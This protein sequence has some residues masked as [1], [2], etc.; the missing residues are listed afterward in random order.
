MRTLLVTYPDLIGGYD[1]PC[2]CINEV[3][4]NRSRLRTL[5]AVTDPGTKQPVETAGHERELKVTVH[6]HGYRRG[7]SI[8]VEEVDPISDGVFYE[9]SLGI[10]FDQFIR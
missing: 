1:N 8:H 7:E 5:I 4:E 9:H 6:L 3:P 10:A 2:R